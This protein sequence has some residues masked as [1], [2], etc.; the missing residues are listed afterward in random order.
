M[1]RP[2]LFRAFALLA[3]TAIL[4]ACSGGSATINAGGLNGPAISPLL[5]G[6][7]QDQLTKYETWFRNPQGSTSPFTPGADGNL[8]GTPIVLDPQCGL[9]Y[10]YAQMAS[11]LNGNDW[12]KGWDG[13][14]LDP[15]RIGAGQDT[16]FFNPT[17][18]Q[19]LFILKG[20]DILGKAACADRTPGFIPVR[21]DLASGRWNVEGFAS[22]GATVQ[23][24]ISTAYEMAALKNEHEIDDSVPAYVSPLRLVRF[25]LTDANFTRVSDYATLSKTGPGKRIYW[26]RTSDLSPSYTHQLTDVAAAG[27]PVSGGTLCLPAVAFWANQNGCGSIVPGL[28]GVDPVVAGGSENVGSSAATMFLDNFA[29]QVPSGGG[30]LGG[31][32]DNVAGKNDD[33][34]PGDT[35]S[36]DNWQKVIDLLKQ[37]A[38]NSSYTDQRVQDPALVAK[39]AAIMTQIQAILN[40]QTGTGVGGSTPAPCALKSGCGSGSGGPQ[41]GNMPADNALPSALGGWDNAG[42]DV[43][44]VV[45]DNGNAAF[46]DTLERLKD[47]SLPATEPLVGFIGEPNPGGTPL[48]ETAVVISPSMWSA[49]VT[50]S[51]AAQ[52]AFYQ[53]HSFI[54]NAGTNTFNVMG[55]STDD[56]TKIASSSDQA[57]IS[58]DTPG[59]PYVQSPATR[60]EFDVSNSL[61]T[62]TAVAYT[63]AWIPTLALWQ[64]GPSQGIAIHYDPLFQFPQA[65]TQAINGLVYN[66]YASTVGALSSSLSK[67]ASNNLLA[68]PELS[69]YQVLYYSAS[70]Q[71]IY[72]MKTDAAGK[73]IA[74]CSTLIGAAGF[75]P[76]V[77]TAVADQ[78]LSANGVYILWVSVR[79]LALVIFILLVARYFYGL[80]LKEKANIKPVGFLARAFLALG[81]ILG[82]SAIIGVLARVIAETILVTDLIGTQLSNGVPYSHLW[83]FASYLSAPNH[84]VGVFL[85]MLLAPFMIIGFFVLLVVNWLRIVMS[86]I[87]IMVSPIWV[88]SLMADPAMRTFYSGLRIMMRLYLIPLVSLVILLVL[89]LLAKTIGVTAGKGADPLGAVIGMLMLIAL[90]IIPLILSEYITAP[91]TA[92]Q[93]AITGMLKA[94]DEAALN[95]QLMEGAN[96]DSSPGLPEGIKNPLLA[97]ASALGDRASALGDRALD[98]LDS[99][100]PGRG[101]NDLAQL[102]A[103]DGADALEAARLDPTEELDAASEVPELAAGTAKP[104][105]GEVFELTTGKGGEIE[106]PIKQLG[107]GLTDP[108]TQL[109]LDLA[110]QESDYETSL[111]PFGMGDKDQHLTDDELDELAPAATRSRKRRLLSVGKAATLMA[112]GK[113]FDLARDLVVAPIVDEMAGIGA[114]AKAGLLP[115]AAN[116]TAGLIGTLRSGGMLGALT[117]TSLIGGSNWSKPVSSAETALMHSRAVSKLGK[118]SGA[119]RSAAITAG[120]AVTERWEKAEQNK[121]VAQ[122]AWQQSEG[123][124]RQV[125]ARQG[126]VVRE[127]SALAGRGPSALA[128][129]PNKAAY[130]EL[131]QIDAQLSR[132]SIAPQARATLVAT[133][134]QLATKNPELVTRYEA[135]QQNRHNFVAVR[136]LDREIARTADPAAAKT[137]SGQR[138]AILDANPTW[139]ARY[140]EVTSHASTVKAEMGSA[141]AAAQTAFVAYDSVAQ[142]PAFL[143]AARVGK[144]VRQ[145]WA[146]SGALPAGMDPA[147]LPA[148]V[149][150]GKGRLGQAFAA[151]AAELIGAPRVDHVTAA[152][153]ARLDRVSEGLS[154][155]LRQLGSGPTDPAKNALM[156]DLASKLAR[157][158]AERAAIATETQSRSMLVERARIARREQAANL[159]VELE[160]ARDMVNGQAQTVRSLDWLHERTERDVRKGRLA[161]EALTRVDARLASARADQT[162]AEVRA[163]TLEDNISRLALI[164]T[165]PR[166]ADAAD[167]VLTLTRAAER[168]QRRAQLATLETAKSNTRR[169]NAERAA[170]E[171]SATKPGDSDALSPEGVQNLKAWSARVGAGRS[172]SSPQAAEE[173]EV[174]EAAGTL[175]DAP[176]QPGVRVRRTDT[177]RAGVVTEVITAT[178][179]GDW[180]YA[181]HFDGSAETEI[182]DTLG[183]L[184]KRA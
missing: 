184:L 133:R 94:A 166:S 92:M 144:A 30:G 154:S 160:G 162:A 27:L 14:A 59:I 21:L 103:G 6:L 176:F 53:D 37:L 171:R 157:A 132:Q 12:S 127:V 19:V 115:D 124:L 110:A 164:A 156:A 15:V 101:G 74:G 113:S 7:S 104:T 49:S 97:G 102:A 180:V 179:D 35:M 1:R 80:L 38:Q 47:S 106:D 42:T 148:G 5:T 86:I 145:A 32:S 79:G 152:R 91:V 117:G 76:T 90:A 158:D 95:R 28:N 2:T 182:E 142:A 18:Q 155:Q 174:E 121:A 8:V 169:A 9:S 125:E 58:G 26:F 98:A 71:A 39:R 68:V 81:I 108:D 60:F 48:H 126:V 78:C 136:R 100:L 150:P 93:A 77:N 63:S 84:D 139:S 55:F 73:P 119:R 149:T 135:E 4:A 107:F 178:T 129:G 141:K 122:V 118:M 111:L 99:K 87:L 138:Q 161:P 25:A 65:V 50:A 13:L 183:S 61:D 67:A 22:P 172:P 57:T 51:D 46:A 3:V 44:G 114:Q 159:G 70:G 130:V 177:G 45:A 29:R 168:S 170:D 88:I 173:F 41:G 23:I 175:S 56:P 75:D 128:A 34:V 10:A 72:A 112:A 123:A 36:G 31:G 33:D 109:G 147:T 62:A 66:I 64:N 16:G 20:Y 40:A 54:F 151:G 120:A 69:Q 181:V 146:A 11:R 163:R 43:F 165:G 134:A 131:R 85:L 167:A 82:M 83:L 143:P 89:F 96:L 137:L 140:R 24:K 153:A 116:P 52:A 17:T 105:E